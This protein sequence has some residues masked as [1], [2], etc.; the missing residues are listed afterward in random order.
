MQQRVKIGRLYETRPLYVR[1]RCV[2]IVTAVDIIVLAL[3]FLLGMLASFLLRSKI[4][5]FNKCVKL[6]K[7]LG[8][9]FM[10]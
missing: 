3:S 4:L 2:G 6:P 5:E 9:I 7:N 1:L 8:G 10:V